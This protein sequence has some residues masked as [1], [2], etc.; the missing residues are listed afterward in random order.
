MS[1]LRSN[2]LTVAALTT[3]P[4]RLLFQRSTTRWGKPF[5]RNSCCALGRPRKTL[6][7]SWRAHIE[8]EVPYDPRSGL[9]FF[10][11]FSDT[12]H[13]ARSP[14]K[15]RAPFTICENKNFRVQVCVTHG[16]KGLEERNKLYKRTHA[17]KFILGGQILIWKFF[18]SAFHCIPDSR[19]RTQFDSEWSDID[20]RSVKMFVRI[21]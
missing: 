4:I 19:T 11:N 7:L 12:L 21:F 15:T 3:E 17:L 2:S 13:M 6:F 18:I 10:R 16:W 5:F 8:W 9:I 20:K 1:S 14:S